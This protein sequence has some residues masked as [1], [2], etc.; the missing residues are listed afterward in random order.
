M[1]VGRKVGIRCYA[2]SDLIDVNEFDESISQ[3]RYYV[4]D[5]FGVMQY[6]IYLHLVLA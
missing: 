1:K 6:L 2:N 5:E 3:I 4:I